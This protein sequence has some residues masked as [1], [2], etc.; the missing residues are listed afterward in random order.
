[1]KLVTKDFWVKVA[2]VCGLA[3]AFPAAQVGAETCLSPYIKGLKTPEKVMYLWALPSTPGEGEDFLAVIDVSLASPTYGKILKKIRVGSTGNEAHH[4]GYTDDRT[5][6]WAASLNSDR[7]FIFDVGA[8]PMNPKLIKVI[9]NVAQLTGLSGP[10]TPY[11][12]PGRILVSMASGPDGKGTGGIAEFTNDGQF[13]TSHKATNNPYETVIKPEFNR[14]ITSTWFP[15]ETW[16]KPFDQWDPKTWSHPNTLLVW[17]LKERKII[18]TLDSG[19]DAVMLAAR[20]MLKPGAK[21]GYNISSG[22]NSI[23]MFRMEADGKFSYRKAGDTGPSCS[24]ADLRQSP[25][26]K[27]LYVSC[28]VGSEIQAW[29]ISDPEHIKLHDTIQG[30]VQPNMMHVT[31]DGRRLYFTNSAISSIDYSSRYSMQLVQIGPDG[32]MKLD[33]NFKIDFT[34]APEGPARPHDML[35]N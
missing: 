6:I 25:D 11:A 21:Y 1:M 2:L 27:F 13:I 22:G 15:Q 14:M 7:L 30:V 8:D 28:F 5:K 9:E 20:W 12:I 3:A 19:G 24:P 16:M 32:R 18:Q 26:D 33:P 10:H 35:L 34:K 17:D 31:F 4:V 29:D 23:W